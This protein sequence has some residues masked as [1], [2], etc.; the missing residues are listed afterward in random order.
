MHSEA[1]EIPLEPYCHISHLH[2]GLYS[3]ASSVL[4]ATGFVNGQF[5]IPTE[6]TPLNRSPKNCHR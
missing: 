5:S 6:S 2:H 1:H 4:T 3:S